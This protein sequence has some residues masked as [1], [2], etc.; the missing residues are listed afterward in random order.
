MEQRIKARRAAKEIQLAKKKLDK[1][2]EKGAF[3]EFKQE[4]KRSKTELEKQLE[5]VAGRVTETGQLPDTTHLARQR[6]CS[7]YGHT[8]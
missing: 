6:P 7:G 3:T 2:N 5:D 4:E 8:T 1:E